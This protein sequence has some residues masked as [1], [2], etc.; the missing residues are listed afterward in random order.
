MIHDEL[1]IDGVKITSFYGKY[2]VASYDEALARAQEYDFIAGIRTDEKAEY[3]M[4]FNSKEEFDEL[5]KEKVY[6][7]AIVPMI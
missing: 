1:E 5:I 7:L 3:G 4:L 6:P 2:A